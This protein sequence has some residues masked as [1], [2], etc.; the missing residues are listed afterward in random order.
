MAWGSH[1]FRWSILKP[2]S[3]TYTNV[4]CSICLRLCLKYRHALC[5]ACMTFETAS[6]LGQRRN[7]H[8][9]ASII[10][11]ILPLES[12]V[13]LCHWLPDPTRK[14]CKLQRF[15]TVRLTLQ[16]SW[17]LACRLLGCLRI[18][19]LLVGCFE[20]PAPEVPFLCG[21]KLSHRC[22]KRP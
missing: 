17:L 14:D 20:L 10:S 3:S 2:S 16:K 19:G 21:R 7:R 6:N 9:L 11:G 12:D 8:L 22:W 13:F 4:C 1:N 18:I 5:R 15:W